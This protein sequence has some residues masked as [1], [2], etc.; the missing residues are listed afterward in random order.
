MQRAELQSKKRWVVKIGSSLLTDNGRGL[1]DTVVARLAADIATLRGQGCDVVLVSSGS[2]AEG[3][4]RLGL[5][6]RPRALHQLQAAA[7][8][9][10]MGLVQSYESQ[11]LTH[12]IRTAQI[13]LTH[14]D[15]ANRRRYLNAR[16]TLQQLLALGV[17]PIVNENDTVTTDEIRFGDNDTLGALVANLIQA[18]VLALLTDQ[19]GLYDSDPRH[20]PAAKR[21]DSGVAGDPALRDLAGPSATSVGS[22]GMVTKILAAEKAARSGTATLIVSGAEPDVLE[23][24]RAGEAIGTLLSPPD[25]PLVARKR[26]LASQLVARGHVQIDQGAVRVLQRAGSSLLPVG[27]QSVSGAFQRG[28]LVQILSPEG[29]EIGRGLCNYSSEESR[30]IIGLASTRIEAALGFVREPEMVHRDNLV[31]ALSIEAS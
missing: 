18:D 16:G 26:W 2:I 4:A 7:A 22:G 21:I 6:T 5:A 28:D 9:G 31:L 1:D 29:E 24:C 27:V 13:L 8:V 19:P 23:R 20:N 3:V 30:K 15:L 25:E 10:Q 11:F 17:L 12:G 14:D